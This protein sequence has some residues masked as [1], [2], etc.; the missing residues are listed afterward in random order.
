LRM[1][2]RFAKI[3][4]G[5]PESSC[6][7]TAKKSSIYLWALYEPFIK[8]WCSLFSAIKLLMLLSSNFKVSIYIYHIWLQT[9]CQWLCAIFIDKISP[10]P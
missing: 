3:R 1:S 8:P 6:S 10:S 9:K 5:R 4:N 2:R 7:W